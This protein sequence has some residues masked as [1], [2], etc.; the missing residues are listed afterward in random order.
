MDNLPIVENVVEENIFIYD[1]DIEDFIG[2]LA[3]RSIGK[4]ENTVKLLRYNNH[5]IYVNNIDNFFK[6][7]RCPTYD[8]F[9]H[10]A[11]QFNRHLLCCRD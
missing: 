1:I 8:T 3:K 10:K 7:F 11:D 6:C 4:Y 5:N 9:F 2:E